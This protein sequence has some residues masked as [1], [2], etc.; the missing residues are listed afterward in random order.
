MIGDQRPKR[1]WDNIDKVQFV[2]AIIA[3]IAILLLVLTYR[4]PAD[5]TYN[6]CD[7]VEECP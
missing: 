3:T 1:Y 6:H 7:P 2:M 4:V 5:E